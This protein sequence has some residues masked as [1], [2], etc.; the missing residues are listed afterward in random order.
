MGRAVE[1]KNKMD[2]AKETTKERKSK[3]IPKFAYFAKSCLAAYPDEDGN[4]L[5]VGDKESVEELLTA[6]SILNSRSA[7][8]SEMLARPGMA[9]TLAA[10]ACQHGAKDL[11]NGTAKKAAEKMAAALMRGEGPNS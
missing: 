3:V 7:K 1:K 5:W 11:I 9:V 10:A 2:G 8:N 6:S 4:A